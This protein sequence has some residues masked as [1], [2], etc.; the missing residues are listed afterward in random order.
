MSNYNSLSNTS[1]PIAKAE[2]S[3]KENS[4]E[5]SEQSEEEAPTNFL[6]ELKGDDPK[7]WGIDYYTVIYSAAGLLSVIMLWLYTVI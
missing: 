7:I 1:L 6:E 5:I 4:E 3:D 2:M